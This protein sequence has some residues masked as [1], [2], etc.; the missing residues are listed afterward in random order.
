MSDLDKYLEY[1]KSIDSKINRKQYDYDMWFQTAKGVSSVEFGERVQTSGSKQKM[2]YAVARYIEIEKEIVA[3]LEQKAKF[4]RLIEQL[5]ENEY[6][7]LHRIYIQGHSVKDIQR[8]KEKSYSWVN[9]MHRRAKR[10][11][12]K[13]K[14]E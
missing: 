3:L 11:L 5:N 4:I 6:E 10:N 14:G 2:E 7:V 9:T 12:A 13:L 8:D 1:I